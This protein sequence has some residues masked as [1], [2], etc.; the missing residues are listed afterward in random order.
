[1]ASEHDE[2]VEDEPASEGDEDGAEDDDVD[3]RSG[4]VARLVDGAAPADSPRS[5]FAWVNPPFSMATRTSSTS[6]PGLRPRL[7]NATV[8]PASKR[9]C[10]PETRSTR[11]DGDTM[12]V[13]RASRWSDGFRTRLGTI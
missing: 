6:S 12:G 2:P 9:A 3:G 5:A 7:P 10:T 13:G 8:T 11:R 4:I 1:M